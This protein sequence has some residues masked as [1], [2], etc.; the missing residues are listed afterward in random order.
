[1]LRS[2]KAVVLLFGRRTVARRQ[3]GLVS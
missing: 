2:L 1:M 3:C